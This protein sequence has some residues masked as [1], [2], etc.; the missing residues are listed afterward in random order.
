MITTLKGNT[1]LCIYCLIALCSQAINLSAQRHKKIISDSII[2][3]GKVVG[4]TRE[5]PDNQVFLVNKNNPIMEMVKPNGSFS[6]TI[7]PAD[8]LLFRSAGFTEK[9]I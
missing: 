2:V 1:K 7:L 3:T 9:K 5:A 6:I 4:A 8:T